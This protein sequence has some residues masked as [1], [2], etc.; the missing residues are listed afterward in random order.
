MENTNNTFIT[1]KTQVQAPL[2]KVWEVW[3]KP[4]HIVRWNAASSD[5]HTHRAVN[6]LRDGGRFLARMESRDGTMGF[7]FSGVYQQVIPFSLI[8][9][10]LDDGRRVRVSFEGDQGKT[11]VTETFEAEHTHSAELQQA[12]W[13]AIL[14]NFK[15]Y[16]E[17]AIKFLP[18]HFEIEIFADN[19]KVYS[20]ML[21]DK[22]Y[23]EWTAAFNPSSRFEGNW[24]KGSKIL[25]FG[26]NPDGTQG[27][28]VSRIRANIP[29]CYV[30]IEHLG[31]ISNGEEITSGN[32]VDAWSGAMENYSFTEKDGMTRVAVDVDVTPE[33]VEYFMGTWPDALTA[34]KSI[35]ESIQK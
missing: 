11:S 35:C 4:E 34:L 8:E 9:Y 31:M 6:D 24:E 23:R 33:F 25:F 20:N 29:G 14:D 28:M 19:E 3:T 30:S 22:Y 18:L 13:Q 15:I 2:E 10:L 5:W 21:D 32:E 17:N 16:A 27:G 12:G 26:E 1:V 7:D